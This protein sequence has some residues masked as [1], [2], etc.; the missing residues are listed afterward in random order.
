MMN[1]ADL[2]ER[3][4]DRCEFVRQARWHLNMT[5]Q[6][7]ADVLYVAR[8]TITRYENG[9]RVPER[10]LMQIHGLLAKVQL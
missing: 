10:S 4:I 1:I 9:A 7:L 5:Q 6:E 3:G 2:S 8:E